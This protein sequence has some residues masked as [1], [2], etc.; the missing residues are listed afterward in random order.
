MDGGGDH[1]YGGGV[2]DTPFWRGQW[3]YFS[4]GRMRGVERLLQPSGRKRKIVQFV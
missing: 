3:R 1:C 2:A 4:W